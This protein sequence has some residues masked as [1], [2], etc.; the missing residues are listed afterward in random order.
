MFI[1]KSSLIMKTHFILAAICLTG[2]LVSCQNKFETI[3]GDSPGEG[4]LDPVRISDSGLPDETLDG[5]QFQSL[6]RS[7]LKG[8]APEKGEYAVIV[9]DAQVFLEAEEKT[10]FQLPAI[11]FEKYSLVVGQWGGV[12]FKA[13][14]LKSQRVL[15]EKG[16]VSLYLRIG[17]ANLIMPQSARL[18]LHYFGALYEKLPDGPV[19]VIRWEDY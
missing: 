8:S 11:D 2:L 16:G 19:K 18:T 3:F 13:N 5:E 15:K 6:V 4:V 10:G 14:Y 1:K 7:F 17:D 12:S 9:N